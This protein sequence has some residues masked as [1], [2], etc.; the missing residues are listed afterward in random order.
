M[1]TNN[2]TGQ[3]WYIYALNQIKGLSEHR[4]NLDWRDSY[5]FRREISDLGRQIKEWLPMFA[6]K[7]NI[8]P[9]HRSLVSK[10]LMS[11]LEQGR[12][13]EADDIKLITEIA[14]E[15]IKK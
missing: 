12:R 2:K 14:N 1:S 13:W 15:L 10:G 6:D 3:K 4:N 11:L 8:S 5:L 9:K 7:E